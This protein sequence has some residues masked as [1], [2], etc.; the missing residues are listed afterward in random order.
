MNPVVWDRRKLR[1]LGTEGA[2]ETYTGTYTLSQ[3]W[4]LIALLSVRLKHMKVT[5]NPLVARPCG[6]DS[7]LRH[8]TVSNA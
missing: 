5:Q 7:L 3:S 8:H 4:I 1:N 6:F 2:A